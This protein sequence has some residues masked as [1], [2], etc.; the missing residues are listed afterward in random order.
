MTQDNALK[1]KELTVGPFYIA[2]IRLCFRSG[3][4]RK[5]MRSIGRI[6]PKMNSTWIGSRPTWLKFLAP[7]MVGLALGNLAEPIVTEVSWTS[8]VQLYTHGEELALELSRKL[9]QAI[10]SVVENPDP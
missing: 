9:D 1:E 8:V 7:F 2:A 3:R 10:S 5:I 6:I 4:C